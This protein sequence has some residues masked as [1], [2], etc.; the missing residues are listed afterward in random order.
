MKHW[1]AFLFQC[2]F[3]QIHYFPRMQML[4]F[5]HIFSQHCSQQ[6]LLNHR[7]SGKQQRLPPQPPSSHPTLG[8]TS[9]WPQ[10]VE[11]VDPYDLPS[12]PTFQPSPGR[13]CSSPGSLLFLCDPRSPG[14][15]HSHRRL[16]LG[17]GFSYLGS[18]SLAQALRQSA[19]HSCFPP[20]FTVLGKYA[21]QF[22]AFSSLIEDEGL[23]PPLFYKICCFW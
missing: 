9:S 17:R 21:S 18:F 16:L 7:L 15:G 19:C 8:L 20:D 2:P 6:S 3:H 4:I 11:M 14:P 5:L 12:A 23:S 13:H 1:S 22:V 10:V